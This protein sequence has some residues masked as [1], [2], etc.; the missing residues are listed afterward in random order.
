YEEDDYAVK[1]ALRIL[2]DHGRGMTFL[3]ADGVVPS[4]EDGGYVRRRIMRRAIQQGRV[5]GVD[6][7]FLPQ[8]C[9]RVVEVMG[10]AY[11]ELRSERDAILGWARDEDMHFRRTLT[12]GERLLRDLVTRAREEGTSWIAAEDAF[13]LHDTYGFPY[14][15]TK[16]LLGEEG[17]A[18]DDQGFGELMERAREVA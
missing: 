6:E 17:L 18:V 12:Q 3:L 7:P 13:R 9:E 8:L 10:D 2:A 16:E 11:P 15:L 1:R 4:D 5:L 14:E